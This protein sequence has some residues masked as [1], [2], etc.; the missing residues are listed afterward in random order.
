MTRTRFL[1]VLVLALFPAADARAQGP[2]VET[3]RAV[4]T[5]YGR[6]EDATRLKAVPAARH[7]VYSQDELDPLWK[8]WFPGQPVPAVD[9]TTHLVVV[10]A[11]SEGTVTRVQV[12][13]H[14]GVGHSVYLR[15]DIT[16]GAVP[17]FT[18]GIAVVPRSKIELFGGKKIPA[19]P[20]AK[21]DK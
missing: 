3:N 21:K 15:A 5:W 1:P 19:L 2:F 12:G 16:P 4:V 20:P 9:F 10:A 7:T 11:T 18:Y 14:A 8:A 17:G 6:I 13:D